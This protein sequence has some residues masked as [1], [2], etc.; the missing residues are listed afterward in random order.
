MFAASFTVCPNGPMW[1]SELANATRPYRETRPYVGVTPTTPQKLAGWR[2]DPPV[3]EPSVTTAVPCATAAADPPL[4]P[5]GTRSRARGLRTGP[6]AE[7]SFEEPMAN[8]SQFNLPIR[9]APSASNRYT[10]VAS[11]G[12]TYFSSAREPQV[13]R[14]SFVTMTSLTPR[15]TP[16]RAPGVNPDAISRSTRAA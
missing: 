13:V 15:G 6:N 7:F 8:S 3:S 5:P 9:M 2:M 14:S 4:E 16:A 1:S 11:Y 10:A 12:G